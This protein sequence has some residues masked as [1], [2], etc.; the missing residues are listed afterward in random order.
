MT[1]GGGGGVDAMIISHSFVDSMRVRKREWR[2]REGVK[3][4]VEQVRNELE[5][6]LVD[7]MLRNHPATRILLPFDQLV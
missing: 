2:V 5:L 4:A 1:G 6:V 7:M 3:A